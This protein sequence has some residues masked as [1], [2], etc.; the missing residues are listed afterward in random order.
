[1]EKV[2]ALDEAAN[3]RFGKGNSRNGPKRKKVDRSFYCLS[4]KKL[5]ALFYNFR[6]SQ[7]TVNFIV[8]VYC[9]NCMFYVCAAFYTQ[10]YA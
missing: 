4:I 1:M 7:L 6:R 8:G 10:L 3:G 5:F 9:A 2:D